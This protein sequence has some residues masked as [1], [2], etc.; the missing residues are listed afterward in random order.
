MTQVCCIQSPCPC[1]MPLPTC[2]S[3]GNTQTLK[4]RSGQVSVRS[5]GPGLHQLD[6]YA[7]V[8]FIIY[9][10][11]EDTE[12]KSISRKDD[13]KHSFRRN[14]NSFLSHLSDKTPLLAHIQ[15]VVS[16]AHLQSIVSDQSLTLNVN[17]SV[18]GRDEHHRL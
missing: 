7:L 12:R 3:A 5:L 8:R 1:S 18:Q 11:V 9:S 10:V 2:A 13:L 6:Q 14:L 15:S 4:G 16:L 17:W